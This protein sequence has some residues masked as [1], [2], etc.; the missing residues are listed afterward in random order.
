MLY[1]IELRAPGGQI[2]LCR[3]LESNRPMQHSPFPMLPC[4]PCPHHAACC[5][6]GTT[7]TE[8]EAIEREQG[9]GLVY[10]SRWGEWRTR[11]RKGRCVFLFNDSCA[12]YN[13]PYYPA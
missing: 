11:V 5:S 6:Y 10:R 12:I 4:Y 7:L 3:R 13:K 1:P 2:S 8:A 9:P